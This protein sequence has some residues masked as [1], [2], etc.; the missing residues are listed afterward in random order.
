MIYRSMSSL[1]LTYKYF[2]CKGEEILRDET[3]QLER[4]FFEDP[5]YGPGFR[6]KGDGCLWIELF[7]YS[8]PYGYYLSLNPNPNVKLIW[9]QPPL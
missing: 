4:V 3:K 5:E 7:N 1:V 2:T 9:R 6:L 8:V